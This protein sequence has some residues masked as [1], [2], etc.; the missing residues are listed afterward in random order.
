MEM[1]VGNIN[2]SARRTLAKVLQGKTLEKEVVK[3]RLSF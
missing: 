3:Y 1:K 2:R